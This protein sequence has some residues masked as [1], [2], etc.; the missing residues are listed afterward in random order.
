MCLWW[1]TVPPPVWVPGALHFTGFHEREH[2]RFMPFWVCRGR[3]IISSLPC[4]WLGSVIK[5]RLMGKKQTGLILSYKWV[6][7]RKTE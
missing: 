7:P 5:D 3:K 4:S 6:I 1:Q 2:L